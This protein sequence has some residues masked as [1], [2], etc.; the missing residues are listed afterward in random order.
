[1][2]REDLKTTKEESDE[3]MK[4]I[5]KIKEK[6]NDTN[7]QFLQRLSNKGDDDYFNDTD[8]DIIFKEEN[9]EAS[10]LNKFLEKKRYIDEKEN[11][12]DEPKY[13]LEAFLKTLLVLFFT[14]IINEIND[15]L[16]ICEIIYDKKNT[17]KKTNPKYQGNP[18]ILN[19]KKMLNKKIKE[20]LN[21]KNKDLIDKIYAKK[22][23]PSTKEEIELYNYLEMTLREAIIKIYNDKPY[24]FKHFRTKYDDWNIK[25]KNEKKKLKGFDLLYDYGLIKYYEMN[26]NLFKTLVDEGKNLIKECN[27]KENQELLDID[28]LL[29]YCPAGKYPKNRDVRKN[30]D[31]LKKTVKELL[32][33]GKDKNLMKNKSLIDKIYKVK[34]FPNTDELKKLKEFLEM[35]ISEAIII[36]YNDNDEIYL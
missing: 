29:L 20:I 7:V 14:C 15:K 17:F 26:Q 2:I 6:A 22:D 9:E 4:V 5:E 21:Y 8:K 31:L 16:M 32:T 13:K 11:S 33:E 10:K 23:F 25:F 3:K 35:P 30:A 28:R 1:M 24:E 18:N 36:F 27:F 12:N 19:G 34:D